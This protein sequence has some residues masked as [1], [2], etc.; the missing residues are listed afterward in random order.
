MRHILLS[1]LLFVSACSSRNKSLD[2]D[3]T[4]LSD[5]DYSV[6]Y[7]QLNFDNFPTIET[8]DVDPLDY[9]GSEGEFILTDSQKA[10]LQQ[11]ISDSAYYSNGDCG[12]FHTNALILVLKDETVRGII[13]I[14][15]G[16]NQWEFQPYNSLTKWGG[17]N[18]EG[19][20]L[21]SSLL[22]DINLEKENKSRTPA[23][24]SLPKDDLCGMKHDQFITD[25]NTITFGYF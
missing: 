15:C 2:F 17:L 12:T 16:Y 18:D 14:R 13:E 6:H 23:R 19:F 5:K 10:K 3:W 1:L 8:M 9:V 22:D 11:L 24:A 7:V 25:L 20:D 21:M 4:Q